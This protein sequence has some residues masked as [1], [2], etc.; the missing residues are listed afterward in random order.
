MNRN[1]DVGF[2]QKRVGMQDQDTPSR[3]CFSCFI[4]LTIKLIKPEPRIVSVINF[5]KMT[6]A[7]E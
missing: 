1:W 2:L 4:R 6:L 3:P 5:V 7:A